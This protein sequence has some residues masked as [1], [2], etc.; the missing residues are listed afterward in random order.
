MERALPTRDVGGVL[1]DR[2]IGSERL[3]ISDGF[4]RN[5]LIHILLQSLYLAIR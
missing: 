4:F 2:A 5:V 1:I 3:P